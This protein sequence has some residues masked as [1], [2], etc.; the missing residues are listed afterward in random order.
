MLAAFSNLRED[1]LRSLLYCPIHSLL[2]RGK[3]MVLNSVLDWLIY[4]KI[5]HNMPSLS[6]S[7]FTTILCVDYQG[8]IPDR[9]MCIALILNLVSHTRFLLLSFICA[10]VMFLTSDING[11]T[12]FIR[13][14]LSNECM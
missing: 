12:G 2:S 10:F 7:H 14:S 6:T 3:H 8:I 4:G 13:D 9:I 1:A 5:S 11:T